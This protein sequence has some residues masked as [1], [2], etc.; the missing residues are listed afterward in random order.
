METAVVMVETV[1]SVTAM[2]SVTAITDKLS[3]GR[4]LKLL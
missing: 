1:M 4:T 2:V 3:F